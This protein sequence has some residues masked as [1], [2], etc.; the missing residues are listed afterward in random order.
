MFYTVNDNAVVPGSFHP[1]NARRP[2]PDTAVP[3]GEVFHQ[4]PRTRE[5][6][7]KG[8]LW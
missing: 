3:A 7:G 1:L 4:V 2:G 8:L 6:P 5:L